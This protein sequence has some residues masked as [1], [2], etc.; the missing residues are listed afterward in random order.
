MIDLDPEATADLSDEFMG[1]LLAQFTRRDVNLPALNTTAAELQD[2]VARPDADS[3]EVARLVLTDQGLSSHV[4]RVANSAAYAPVTRI[5][6]V[7][8]AIARLGLRAM[9]EMAVVLMARDQLF[10]PLMRKSQ[11]VQEMWRHAAVAG[12]YSRRIGLLRRS[13]NDASVLTG[14][15]ADVGQPVAYKVLRELSREL[16]QELS[17]ETTLY[18]IEV[19]HVPMGT[20]LAEVWRLPEPVSIAIA[21]HHEYDLAREHA[22]A[23]MTANLA[24]KLAD[25]C[26]HPQTREP[27]SLRELPVIA[28]L[29][30]EPGELGAL[31]ADPDE[32]REAAAAF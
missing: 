2:M 1:R 9:G 6:S 31:F 8:Q 24:D 10:G 29:G 4:L 11:L 19:L 14:L 17:P 15:L 27:T 26:L 13:G 23:A 30:L 25:W 20:L 18:L 12:V 28:D 21:Y 22:Q 5:E 7:P 3:G 32:A 16:G